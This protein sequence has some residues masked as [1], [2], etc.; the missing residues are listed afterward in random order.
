MKAT[1]WILFLALLATMLVPMAGLAEDDPLTRWAM[2]E[3]VT[4]TI[5]KNQNPATVNYADGEDATNN[6]YYNNYRDKLGITMDFQIYASGDEY[7]QKLT[8]AIAS[9][10]LP[11]LLYLP[12]D[13]YILLARG[14]KLWDMTDIL[15][16]YASRSDQEVHQ[17]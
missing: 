4:V 7:S 9:N 3:P 15:D 6:I 17:L 16:E 12:T 5:L 11:D 13:Q 2:D 10:E 14:G 1:C 8:M